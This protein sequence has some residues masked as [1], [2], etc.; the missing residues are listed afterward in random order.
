MPSALRVELES[1]LRARQLD[2]TLTSAHPWSETSRDMAPTGI[3]SLDRALGGGVARGH[4]SEIVGPR[5]SGRT[6][7]LC[8]ML[9]AATDRGEAVAL[10][11]TCDRFDPE[12]AATAGLDLSKLLWVRERGDARRALKAMN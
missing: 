6:T 11:D 9:T 7:V 4:L 3:P 10:I 5:S 1:L 8:R 12:S 2:R